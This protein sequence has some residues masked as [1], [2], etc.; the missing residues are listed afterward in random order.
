MGQTF[1]PKEEKTYT[2]IAAWLWNKNLEMQD[3]MTCKVI[4][5]SGINGKW[6]IHLWYIN[7]WTHLTNG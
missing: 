6:E 3:V 4:C 5:E 2:Y 1:I 7:Y